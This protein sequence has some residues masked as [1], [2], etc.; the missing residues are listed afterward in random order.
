[1]AKA[2]PTVSRVRLDLYP[3]EELRDALDRWR[4]EQPG[5]P[6]RAAAARQLL[7]EILLEKGYFKPVRKRKTPL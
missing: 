2:K 3:S 6:N 1:M 4:F 5:V 7:H